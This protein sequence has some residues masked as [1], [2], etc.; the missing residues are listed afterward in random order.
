VG[1]KSAQRMAF[2]LLQH[3]REGAQ[4]IAF[5]FAIGRRECAPLRALPHLQRDAGVQRVPRRHARMRA[6]SASSRPRP[7]RP[8]LERTG[9]YR[10]LY[11]VLMVRL[12]PLD[13][14]GTADIGA[15]ELIERAPTA[16]P[17]R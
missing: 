5:A 6:S 2:H 7:T 12:S 3:D 17:R 1:I 13:G 9:S 11:F 14:I 4:R 8:P 16:T 15:H 10:G